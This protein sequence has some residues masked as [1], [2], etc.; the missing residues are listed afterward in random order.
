M[1]WYSKEKPTPFDTTPVLG[2]LFLHGDVL[3]QRYKQE[4]LKNHTYPLITFPS[5]I[6]RELLL[7]PSKELVIHLVGGLSLPYQS[8][9]DTAFERATAQDEDKEYHITIQ[10]DQELHIL[11]RTSGRSYWVIYDNSAGH[12]LDIRAFPAHTMELLPG[13]LQATLPKLYSTEQKGTEAI[14]PM[15]FFT[16]DSNWTWYPTEFDGQD[17]FFGLVSGFEVELGYFS[18]SELEGVRGSLGLPVERDL[19]YSPKTLQVLKKE[20]S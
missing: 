1:P 12:L 3:A 11:N 19:F 17:I 5:G 4:W 13:R 10:G 7:S 9:R 2:M 14:A 20:H 15:K 6:E 8:T 18:L 16:P